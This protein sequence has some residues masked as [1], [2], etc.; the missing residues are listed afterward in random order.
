MASLRS[1]STAAFEVPARLPGPRWFFVIVF[2]VDKKNTQWVRGSYL[3]CV[4]SM[5][6][7][8][9]ATAAFSICHC[10]VTVM[11][12]DLAVPW[13]VWISSST[14]SH[15]SVVFSYS[16][17]NHLK[18]IFHLGIEAFRMPGVVVMFR[19]ATVLTVLLPLTAFAFCVIW[20]VTFNFKSATATHCG[21]SKWETNSLTENWNTF[22]SGPQLPPFTFS[23]HWGL[24]SSTLCLEVCDSS[25]YHP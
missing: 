4:E 24:Q 2:L 17:N 22:S 10:P 12:M 16:S 8:F 6:S 3:H 25:T 11:S 19:T 21:V 14:Q 9:T 20:S 7:H 1:R 13:M 18:E 23:C 5:F 15:V